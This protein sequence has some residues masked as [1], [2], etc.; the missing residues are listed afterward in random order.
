MREMPKISSVSVFGLGKLG[1]PLLA[2]LADK[3]YTV[4][5]VDVDQKVVETLA[6]GNAPVEEPGL[7]R[8]IES[9][10]ASIRSTLSISDA[11]QASGLS[12]IIVPTPSTRDGTFSVEFVRQVIQ[13]IGQSLREKMEYHLVVIVSTVMPGDTAALTA[14]LQELSD[15]TLGVNLGVCYSPEFIALGSVI[16]DLTNP[17]MILIGQSDELAGDLYQ[18]VLLSMVEND[19]PVAR[20]NFVNAE[21]AKLAVNGYVTTKITYANTIARICEHVPGADA[22]VITEAI[23]LDSRIGAKYLR[24]AVAYGGPCFPRDNVALAKFAGQVGIRAR[25]PLATHQANLDQSEALLE[26]VAQ[27]RKP[28]A[29]IAVL[30]LAY[31]PQTPVVEE[32]AGIRLLKGLN[33]SGYQAIGYDPLASAAAAEVLED[34]S[35]VTGDLADALGQAAMVI[36]TVPSHQFADLSNVDWER[37]KEEAIILDAWRILDPPTLPGDR[38]IIYLGMGPNQ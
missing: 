33:D 5:G 4:I 17:D 20:M 38:Q 34:E 18:S 31:K 6:T 8:L 2:V 1:S 10:K 15:R 7:Q 16:H 13:G 30:G 11:V 32:S 26:K 14:E 9:N 21:L 35:L 25:L 22:N 36:I 24:G 3:G 27:F 23:G 19:P 28:P 29:K 37:T 12:C